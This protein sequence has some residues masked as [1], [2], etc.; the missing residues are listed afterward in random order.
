MKHLSTAEVAKALDVSPGRV[1]QLVKLGR[2]KNE[3]IGG[4]YIFTQRDLDNYVRLPAGRPAK[5][6]LP[7]ENAP[8]EPVQQISD[9]T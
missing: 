8:Q 9:L 6:P 5:H 7:C 4:R 3:K 1:I 2:I